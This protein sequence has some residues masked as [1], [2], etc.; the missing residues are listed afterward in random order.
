MYWL[1]SVAPILICV[2]IKVICS[3]LVLSVEYQILSE[4]PLI[5]MII[6]YPIYLLYVNLFYIKCDKKHKKIPYICN[7]IYMI[8]LG[9]SVPMYYLIVLIKIDKFYYLAELVATLIDLSIS[10]TMLMFCLPIAI[11]SVGMVIILC[12][13]RK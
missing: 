9:I 4:L 8:I 13:L 1:L 7:Y 5:S 3:V 10:L 6:V 2:A 11:I 12:N